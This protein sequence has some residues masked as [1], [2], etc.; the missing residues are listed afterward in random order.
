MHE[1]KGMMFICLFVLCAAH[2][3]TPCR[4]VDLF[5]GHGKQDLICMQ[6]NYMNLT[7]VQTVFSC[8]RKCLTDKRC[9][10]ANYMAETGLC[11]LGA[12]NC[13]DV[14]YAPGFEMLVI[15]VGGRGPTGESCVSWQ[16]RG[17]TY[18][19][20]TVRYVGVW[21][22]EEITRYEHNYPGHRPLYHSGM[23]VV[24]ANG[25]SIVTA[26][27][28]YTTL[29]IHPSCTIAWR[30]LKATEPMPKEAVVGGTSA[31]GHKLYVAR[32][33]ETVNGEQKYAAGYYDSNPLGSKSI[34]RYRPTIHHDITSNNDIEV[35]IV[36]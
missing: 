11:Y 33:T 9:L 6:S 28:H 36:I 30:P 22:V 18:S 20:N 21:D 8:A 15:H 13:R 26:P 7:N 34:Y 14:E 2:M 29:V 25:E 16:G 27:Y 31:A 35:L 23:F 10:I 5:E 24:S 32:T 12:G 17:N 3:V 1:T 4:E 19:G